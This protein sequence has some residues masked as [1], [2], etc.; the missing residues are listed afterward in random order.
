MNRKHLMYVL[1]ATMTLQFFVSACGNQVGENANP[2]QPNGTQNSQQPSSSTTVI[3]ANQKSDGENSKNAVV[4]DIPVDKAKAEKFTDTAKFL[5]GIK[6]DAGSTL[7]SLQKSKAWNDHAYYFDSSWQRLDAQQLSKI[8][9]WSSN[10]LKSLNQSSDPIFYPFSGPD[11]LYAYSFFPKGSDYVLAGL[12][13]VGDIPDL[14]KIPPEKMDRKLQEITT[15]LNAIL[16]LSFFRTNDMKVDLAEKGV[17]PVLFVFLARTNNKILDV[18]YITLQKDATVQAFENAQK[19][20]EAKNLIPGVKISFLPQGESNPRTLYYFS[21]DLSNGALQ[22]TPEFNTFVKQFPEPTTYLKAASYLMHR[23]DFSNIRDLI[24]AESSSLLQDDSGMPVKY[25]DSSKWNLKFY[26]NY[27][28]PIDLFST[29][30]QGDL[31][32]IYKSDSSIKPLDFGIGYKFQVNESN[33]MLAT[34][35]KEQPAPKP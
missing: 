5:A 13:P 23:E 28:Q 25:V 31:R 3:N 17:L 14:E 18:E 11:F 34:S 30:Y 29:R 4:T 35:K 19:A 6:V 21:V 26:G 20:R 27:T 7:A 8:R 10:E 32:D 16:Q 15:S 9:N 12:E 22:K 2:N 1:S 24:L 33:L